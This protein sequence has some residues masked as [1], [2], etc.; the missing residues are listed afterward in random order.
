[1]LGISVIVFFLGVLVFKWKEAEM[2]E[3]L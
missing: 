1:V 2:V 3:D